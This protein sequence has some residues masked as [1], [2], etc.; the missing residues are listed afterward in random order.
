STQELLNRTI[1]DLTFPQDRAAD[2]ADFQRAGSGEIPDYEFEKR[3]V[4]KDGRIFWGRVNAVILRDAQDQPESTIATIQDITA[5]R[6][7]EE[8]LR[9]ARDELELRVQ[10]RTAELAGSEMRQRAILES[11][12]DGLIV[13]DHEGRIV[14][15]NRSAETI[16]GYAREEV[17]NQRMAG[18]IIP[19]SFQEAHYRGLARC[20]ATGEGPVLGKQLEMPALRSDGTEFPVELF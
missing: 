1:S 4:R 12:V 7:A 19:P 16:F 11:A 13:M 17:L 8:D 10:E 5:R 9:K 3:Y 6:Q 15:F 20:L 18:L 14:D 2:G